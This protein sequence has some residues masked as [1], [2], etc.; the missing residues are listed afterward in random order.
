MLANHIVPRLQPCIFCLAP[1]LL[2]LPHSVILETPILLARSP[3]LDLRTMSS[4][5][6]IPTV[7]P[8]PDA[9]AEAE[10]TG[11]QLPLSASLVLTSLPRDATT[12]LRDAN[13]N[14]GVPE[15]GTFRSCRH[16]MGRIEGAGRGWASKS[17]FPLR[18]LRPLSKWSLLQ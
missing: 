2:D 8:D 13:E 3:T 1:F 16:L 18:G 12:A 4:T 9:E 7:P 14:D 11:L 6:P 15:K 10:E 5:P 17:S